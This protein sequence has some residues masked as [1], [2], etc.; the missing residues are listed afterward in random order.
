MRIKH[1]AGYGSV[2]ATIV[3]SELN[4]AT[5][6]E[7]YII[8][9]WGNHE[10]GLDRSDDSYDVYNWLV[11]K[12]VRNYKN[13]DYKYGIIKNID[14]NYISNIDNQEACEYTITLERQY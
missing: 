3:R 5:N 7:K 2:N 11:K 6:E 14:F 8:R 4:T 9:V 1:W 10:M 13:I 12:T